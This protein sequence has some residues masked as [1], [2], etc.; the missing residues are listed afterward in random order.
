M[1]KVRK[2]PYY[3]MAPSGLPF[4]TS[5]WKCFMG[6]V[7]CVPI[8][9]PQTISFE[10]LAPGEAPPPPKPKPPKPT[11]EQIK[12]Q[13]AE[14]ARQKSL[15]AQAAKQQQQDKSK[16]PAPPKPT[17]LE[18]ED[19]EKLPEFDLQDIPDAMDKIGW[20]VSA[21]VARKWFSSPEYIYND[22]PDSVQP[23]DSENVTLNWV[24][25]YGAVTGR[26][27]ERRARLCDRSAAL[28]I[29]ASLPA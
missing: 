1:A 22:K 20:P 24:L 18:A 28:E 4:T 19:R 8:N 3:Q 29:D 21:K 7:G 25:K 11:P 23:I 9:T 12:A 14:A 17:E 26:L 5:K 15:A 10:R 13:Q 16:Q 6:S 27:H 2:R